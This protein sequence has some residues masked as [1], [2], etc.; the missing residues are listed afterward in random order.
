M[1]LSGALID[2]I[3]MICH[4]SPFFLKKYTQTVKKIKQIL[5]P[6]VKNIFKNLLISQN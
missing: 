3:C 5:S 4:Q 2:V 1:M 6:N